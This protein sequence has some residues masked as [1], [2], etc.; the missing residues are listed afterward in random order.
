MS[1]IQVGAGPNE[2]REPLV[3]AAVYD[4]AFPWVYRAARRLGVH[5]SSLDDVVQDV[6]LVVHRKLDTFERR[7]S[8]KSWIYGITLHVVRGRRRTAKRRPETPTIDEEL[9]LLPGKGD[10][11]SEAMRREALATVLR[12][13]DSLSEEQREVFVLAELEELSVP[14][15]AEASGTNVNTVYSRLRAARKSFEEAAARL[16]AREQFNLS[17]EPGRTR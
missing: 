8:L 4:E 14:E 12:I 1:P 13:L 7:A 5:P 16:R 15:I 17:T 3:F 2:E 6:F 9:A 11:H 10:P